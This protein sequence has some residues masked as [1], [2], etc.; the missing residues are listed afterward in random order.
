MMPRH[1]LLGHS[2]DS[3]GL[4]DGFVDGFVIA[5][6]G[7]GESVSVDAHHGVCP[8]IHKALSIAARYLQ[9]RVVK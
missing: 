3:L 2:V 8:P 4:L 9:G 1:L 7:G 5:I 6:V